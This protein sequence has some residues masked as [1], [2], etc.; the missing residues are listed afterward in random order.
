M[1]YKSKEDVFNYAKNSLKVSKDSTLTTN[2]RAGNLRS[3]LYHLVGAVGSHYD[4]NWRA[5]PVE[6]ALRVSNFYLEY[7]EEELLHIVHYFNSTTLSDKELQSGI[8]LAER[9]MSA[10]SELF[11]KIERVRQ[12]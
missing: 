8:E 10:V 12:V 2:V 9:V 6:D 11:A 7:D 1:D 3:A 4:L 5:V